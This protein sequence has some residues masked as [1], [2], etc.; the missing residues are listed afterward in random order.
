MRSACD[1]RP[2]TVAEVLARA[3]HARA[4][5][6][7]GVERALVAARIEDERV[8]LGRFA[9]EPTEPLRGQ[10]PLR[11]QSGGP[12]WHLRAGATF[13]HLSL[14]HRSALMATPKDKLLNRNLRPM[15]QALRKTGALAMYGGRDFLLVDGDIVALVAWAA[16]AAGEV[17]IEAA[18]ASDAPVMRQ[19]ESPAVRAA[20]LHKRARCVGSSGLIDALRAAYAPDADPVALTDA[21]ELA[22]PVAGPRR[23]AIDVALGTLALH[24]TSDGPRLFGDL[25]AADALDTVDLARLSV[26]ERTHALAA[27]EVEGV[28]DLP[29]VVA[30]LLAQ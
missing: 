12:P 5:V 20:H 1:L 30:A 13:V 29:D 2:G 9:S 17:V 15:L 28:R 21:E 19:D 6:Q 27:I 7:R 18:I 4:S 3:R 10:G 24:D 22:R 23:A 8:V 14:A 25:F 16:G 26:R 11:R